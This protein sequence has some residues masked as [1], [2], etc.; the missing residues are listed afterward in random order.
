MQDISFL[1]CHHGFVMMGRHGKSTLHCGASVRDMI[2]KNTYCGPYQCG[3]VCL[4][5]RDTRCGLALDMRSRGY[6]GYPP[7]RVIG[8]TSTFKSCT[9][10]VSKVASREQLLRTPYN[11]IY[12]PCHI[13]ILNSKEAAHDM[14]RH[15]GTKTRQEYYLGQERIPRQRGDKDIVCL[16]QRKRVMGLENCVL[17]IPFTRAEYLH[18]KSRYLTENLA[19]S[20]NGQIG[21]LP[22][23]MTKNRISISPAAMD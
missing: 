8:V 1:Q 4:T 3:T 16:T 18:G 5:V 10:E 17:R 12:Q 11:R 23:E 13:C 19:V 9:G 21:Y 20:K 22:A 2:T 7:S 6:L 14:E 15:G